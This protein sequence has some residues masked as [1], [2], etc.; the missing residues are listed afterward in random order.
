MKKGIRRVF[1]FLCAF[2]K[3]QTSKQ[4]RG[5]LDALWRHT[6]DS[7]ASHRS[8]VYDL[9]ADSSRDCL[10]WKMNPTLSFDFWKEV[11]EKDLRKKSEH[12]DVEALQFTW[13]YCKNHD[14]VSD[15]NRMRDPKRTVHLNYGHRYFMDKGLEKSEHTTMAF[16]RKALEF[17]AK[18]RA[19]SQHRE[20]FK[21]SLFSFF[22]RKL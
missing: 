9:F 10:S 4:L 22:S 3:G 16:K 11:V 2:D 19:L 13:N 8:L 1:G 15:T 6:E 12:F 5:L 18:G 21:L 17:A 20:E 7:H 14:E